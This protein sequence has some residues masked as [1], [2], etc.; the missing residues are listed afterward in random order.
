[1]YYMHGSSC[2]MLTLCIRLIVIT[3]PILLFVLDQW[4]LPFDISCGFSRHSEASAS[5][6]LEKNAGKIYKRRKLSMQIEWPE[7]L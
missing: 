7:Y 1:M 3:I 2:Q 4:A 6:F 5:V